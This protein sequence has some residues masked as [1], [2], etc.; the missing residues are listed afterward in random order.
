M[1]L[2]IILIALI[3]IYIGQIIFYICLLDTGEFHSKKEFNIGM[4]PFFP[5]INNF[6]SKY[7]MLK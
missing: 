5:I 3:S 7:K 6:I 4:I 2:L 1:I